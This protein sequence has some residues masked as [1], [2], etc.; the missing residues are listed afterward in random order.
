MIYN[1]P[2]G[3]FLSGRAIFF[4]NMPV[5]WFTHV[6]RFNHPVDGSGFAEAT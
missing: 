3:I 4:S 5:P 6:L 1:G 2:L